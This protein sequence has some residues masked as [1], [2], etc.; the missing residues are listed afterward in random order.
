MLAL[1][2]LIFASI[3]LNVT[4][5]LLIKWTMAKVGYFDYSLAN[6]LPIALKIASQ[7]QIFCGLSCYVFSVACWMMVLS[8]MDVSV[9]YPIG[10]IGYIFTALAAAFFFD[11]AITVMRMAGIF[12]I[13]LGVFMITRPA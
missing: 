1:A 10:S 11:E 7:W 8:R 13:M 9:A 12:V 5:Q 3:L 6:A 2:L 4:A